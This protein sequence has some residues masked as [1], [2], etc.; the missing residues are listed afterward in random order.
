M[1]ARPRQLWRVPVASPTVRRLVA[2]ARAATGGDATA[3]NRV[4]ENRAA[5]WRVMWALSRDH[6]WSTPRIGRA[7]GVHHT[8][9]VRAMQAMARGKGA[10]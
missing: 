9:V 3:R 10:P 2:Q 8:T 1:S 4:A 5:R 6:K 7:L